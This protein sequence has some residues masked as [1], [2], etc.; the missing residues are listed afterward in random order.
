VE[1]PEI[2][3]LSSSIDVA[4]RKTKNARESRPPPPPISH[5]NEQFGRERCSDRLTWRLVT[6]LL[7]SAYLRASTARQTTDNQLQE[8]AAAGFTVALH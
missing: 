1:L 8:I 5:C 2:T 4:R 6:Q 7:G 3:V